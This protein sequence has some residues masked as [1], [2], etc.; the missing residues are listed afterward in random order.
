MPE[1]RMH[2]VPVNFVASVLLLGKI[3]EVPL[4][5]QN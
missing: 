3:P 4:L 5:D 2:Q 1:I